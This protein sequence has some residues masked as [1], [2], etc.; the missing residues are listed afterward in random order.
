MSRAKPLPPD[1]R[2]RALIDA[3][4]PLLLAHGT[5]VSTRQIAE[6]AGVAEGTIFRVFESKADL[7]HTCL[8]DALGTDQLAEAVDR[9]GPGA[10]LRSTLSG[11]V[12][13]VASQLQHVR[14]LVGVLHQ[15]P[16][17]TAPAGGA[18]SGCQRPDPRVLHAGVVAQLT[19]ALAP[20]AAQLR[21]P[22][23]AAARTLLALTFGAHHPIAGDPTLSDPDALAT[24]LLH[25]LASD[26][27]KDTACC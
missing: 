23:D 12:A 1:E 3:T 16:V 6:A 20:H 17:A 18:A 5:N 15:T 19:R 9:I 4:R 8:T 26:L 11:L 13:A 24:L 14:A 22:P 21:V 2:R 27:A 7:I 10:D 25:A